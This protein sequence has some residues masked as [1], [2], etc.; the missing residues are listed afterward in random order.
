MSL[1]VTSSSGA[2]AQQQPATQARHDRHALE[3]VS[4]DEITAAAGLIR[5]L[6]PAQTDLHFKV[7]TLLEPP[8]A[9]VLPYLEAEHSGGELPL[10]PRKAFVNYYLRNTVSLRSLLMMMTTTNIG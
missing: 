1:E 6:W 7:I 5:S 4:A 3:P 10:L 9:D 8:K 2:P